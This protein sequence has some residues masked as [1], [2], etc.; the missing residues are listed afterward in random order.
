MPPGQALIRALLVRSAG[1][2]YAL[3]INAVQRT[4]DLECMDSDGFRA[5][6]ELVFLHDRLGVRR[7]GE[8][9]G[10]ATRALILAGQGAESALVVDDVLG[11]Q[12]VILQPLEGPLAHLAQFSGAA[13]TDDGT[14]ALVL[15]P[16]SLLRMA[17]KR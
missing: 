5:G 8:A 12:D 1:G 16:S 3:P 14:I 9:H 15:D 2:L 11:R 4:I 7:F 13:L 17:T 10:R 6:T